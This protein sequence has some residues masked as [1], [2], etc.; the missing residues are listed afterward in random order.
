ML[1]PLIPMTLMME[2][3]IVFVGNILG[4][5]Q[6]TD[7]ILESGYKRESP[8]PLEVRLPSDTIDLK[9]ERPP[10]EDIQNK[11]NKNCS[12]CQVESRM[13]FLN[14]KFQWIFAG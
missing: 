4:L 5:V 9:K 10:K 8:L 11:L 2:V 13:C 6:L 1:P 14:T 7:S 3:G 12:V